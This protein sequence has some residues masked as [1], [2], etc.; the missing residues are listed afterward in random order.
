MNLAWA[1]KL[2]LAR[3][4]K[5]FAL[6][7]QILILLMV[8]LIDDSRGFNQVSE[9]FFSEFRFPLKIYDQLL[10][11]G[12][13]IDLLPFNHNEIFWL[14]ETGRITAYDLKNKQ[15]IWTFDTGQ[16]EL[17]CLYSYDSILLCASPQNSL[18]AFTRE[19]ERLWPESFKPFGGQLVFFE[20]MILLSTLNQNL[21][22]IEP[23]TGKI[24][25]SKNLGENIS[26]LLASPQKGIIVF[27]ASGQIYQL[28]SEERISKL[29]QINGQIL[30]FASLAEDALF[31]GTQKKDL[32]C[33]SIK[34]RKKLWSVQLAGQLVTEPLPLDR[35]LF[36]A[37]SNAVLYCLNQKNGEIRW[38]RSLPSRLAFPLLAIGSIII[39]A[40]PN[41]P[42]LAFDSNSGQKVGEFHF[43]G[44]ISCPPRL[45]PD[46][47]ILAI[48]DAVNE[49][50]RLL[51]LEPHIEVI[52]SSSQPSPQKVGTEIVFVAEAIGFDEPRFEFFLQSGDK[53]EIV[54]RESSRNSW[55]WLPLVPG[56]Y[57]I[58][59]KVKDKRKS[60]ERTI[61]F[62]IV[63]ED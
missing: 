39:A 20:G 24:I 11:E 28:F 63:R 55:M 3:P 46:K 7:S 22:A 23:S 58:G 45:L 44:E 18:W 48:Y 57:L 14:T 50:S 1:T 8:G 19:G 62:Q 6:M 41:P 47:L 5:Y 21:T 33:F 36:I 2:R 32:I 26:A 52:L 4:I 61:N 38:W 10:V 15:I 42:L 54:Q 37:A 34:K 56:D 60:R 51:W 35:S 30:P 43:E 31:F 29:G 13:I 59:V 25:W 17:S 40:T 53:K 9:Q 16:K 27:G 49:E 12:R